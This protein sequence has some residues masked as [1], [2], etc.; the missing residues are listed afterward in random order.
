[1]NKIILPPPRERGKL[2]LEESIMARRSVR[3]FTADALRIEEVSQMLWAGGGKTLEREYRLGRTAPS[4]GGIYPL[5]YYLVAGNVDEIP[6]GVYHY[7][8]KNHSLL[9]KKGGDVRPFLARAALNQHFISRAPASIVIT[10]VVEKTASRY[11]RRGVYRYVPMDA[12][13]SAQNVYLQA[14]A[15]GLGTVDVGAFDDSLV[16][17]VLGVEREEPLLILPFGKPAD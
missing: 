12:G 4:A 13:H 6:E 14:T 11:G 8:W 2:S 15:L 7:S 1:M 16:V 9:L 17:K 5:E 10:A 3:Y